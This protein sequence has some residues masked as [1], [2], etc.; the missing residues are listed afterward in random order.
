MNASIN[1]INLKFLKSKSTLPFTFFLLPYTFYL[2]TL[3]CCG[4]STRSLLPSH[5]QK[6]HIKLFENQT[7]KAG[8]DETAT[9]NVIEAFRGG[10]NLRIVAE[11]EADIVIEGKVTGYNKTPYTYTSDQTVIEY[12]LTMKYSVRCV[13]QVKNDVFWEGSVSDWVTYTSDEEQAL[14]EVAR[15]TAEKLVNTIL[16]NW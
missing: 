14:I 6:V 15:K 11:G 3:S 16:T 1:R 10:S 7:L 8:L 13:D 2:I 9:V 4:Y 12:K 5:I